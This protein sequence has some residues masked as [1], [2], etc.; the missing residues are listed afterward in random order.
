M[1]GTIEAII[2]VTALIVLVVVCDFVRSWRWKQR[3]AYND[4]LLRRRDN[5]P[6]GNLNVD[7]GDGI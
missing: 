5:V 2:V 7:S 6:M 1:N 4:Y 3:V